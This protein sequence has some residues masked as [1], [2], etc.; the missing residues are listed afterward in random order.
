MERAERR[1]L[2]WKL[3]ESKGGGEERAAGSAATDMRYSITWSARSRIDGGI[4]NPSVLAV[5]RLTNR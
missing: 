5:L 1:R 4:V 3:E 2:R